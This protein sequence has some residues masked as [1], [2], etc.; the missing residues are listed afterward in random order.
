MHRVGMLLPC[1]C[2]TV[3]LKNIP[4][5]YTQAMLRD[6]LYRDGY[7]HDIDFLY[8]PVDFRNNVNAGYAFLNFRTADACARFAQEFHNQRCREK[9]PGFNS[10]KICEVAAARFQGRA[11]NADRLRRSPVMAKLIS[12]PEWMPLLFDVY[13][14]VEPFQTT[15][16]IYL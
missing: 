11:V 15:T 3:M 10:H 7:K 4:N 6:R 14:Q 2:T 16:S 9:L 12:T 1:G 8:S 13:G 5:K